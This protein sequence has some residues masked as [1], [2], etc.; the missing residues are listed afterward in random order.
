MKY[1][2]SCGSQ[3][4]EGVS[5][6][7]NC[8][9]PVEAQTNGQPQNNVEMNNQPNNN[10]TVVNQ[11][12]YQNNNQNMGGRPTVQ[13]RNIGVAILLS[14]VTCGIY[15]I[16]WY[17]NLVNEVNTICNDDKSSQSGGVVFLLTLVTC[18]IYGIIWF[19]QAGKRMFNAG[20]KYGMQI[21]DNSTL[22]LIL[23]IFGLSIVDYCLVQ[24][25]LN[26]FSVQ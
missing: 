7:P 19:Y 10:Q 13:N 25:D 22:Y 21:S 15:G 8:G 3:I 9:A 24:A 1:C 6:C 2:S 26:K 16:I 20:Q 18:G 23:A 11:P 17:I 14:I 12:N 5:F 4:P